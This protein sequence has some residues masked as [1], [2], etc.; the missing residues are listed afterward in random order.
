MSN[1]YL[2]RIKRLEDQLRKYID[3]TQ[4]ANKVYTCDDFT[5]YWPVGSAAVVVAKSKA[6]AAT[7]LKEKLDQ[8]G[9]EQEEP[10]T[11]TVLDQSIGHAR[12]L[13]DGDY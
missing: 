12:I 5:G 1:P 6:E 9:L 7:L 3:M 13:C 8:L 10:P 4:A 11:I 2:E